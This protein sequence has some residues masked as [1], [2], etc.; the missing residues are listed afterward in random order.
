MWEI[1][2]TIERNLKRENCK[3]MQNQIFNSFHDSTHCQSHYSH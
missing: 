2:T 1:G 3:A